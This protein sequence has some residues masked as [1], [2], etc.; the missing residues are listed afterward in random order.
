LPA[1]DF[2][3]VHRSYIVPIAKID[4]FSKSKIWV[5]E[6]EIPIGSSYGSVYDQ[7]LAHSQAK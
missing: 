3:R 5:G 2:I 4:K 1:R 7:L 6:K